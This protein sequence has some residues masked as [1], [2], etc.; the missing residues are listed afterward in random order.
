M[1]LGFVTGGHAVVQQRDRYALQA[2]DVYLV[3][4]GERHGFV[5]AQS[6]E[7]WSIGF[8]PACYTTGEFR[9]LLSPFE[10]VCLGASAVVHIPSHR[11]EYLARLCAELHDETRDRDGTAHAD[12]AQKSLLALIL[13]EVGRASSVSSTVGGQATLVGEALRYIERHCLLSISLRDV[14]VAVNR[15]PSHVATIVKKATGKTVVEWITAGRLA[16][17]RNRLV[18]TD[19]PIDTV[20]ERVGYADPTHFIRMFRRAHDATPA[21]WRMRQRS[22]APTG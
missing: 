18:Y 7:A 12:T 15:S 4:A 11:Q 13:T 2:G 17:A 10:R 1:A 5:T 22:R 3:P 6:P 9:A 8:S 14:A 16:E 21:A 19:E 20:A